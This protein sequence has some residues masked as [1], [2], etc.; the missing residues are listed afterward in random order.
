MST[1]IYVQAKHMQTHMYVY[2]YICVCERACNCVRVCVCVWT[3]TTARVQ[4]H[5]YTHIYTEAIHHLVRKVAVM[6]RWTG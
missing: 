1:L 6:K 4:R 3:H 5:T 2:K